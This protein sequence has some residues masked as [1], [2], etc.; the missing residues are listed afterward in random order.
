MENDKKEYR[1]TQ[2]KQPSNTK[3]A[4]VF[5]LTG[6]AKGEAYSPVAVWEDCLGP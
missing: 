4:W 3:A 5:I 2:L 1:S 6:A